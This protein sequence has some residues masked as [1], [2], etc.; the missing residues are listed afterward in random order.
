MQH[1][2]DAASG[3]NAAVEVFKLVDQVSKID[4]TQPTGRIESIGDGSIKFKNVSFWYPH[5]PE[6]VLKSLSFKIS[7]GQSVALV[8]FSGSGKSTVIQLLMR[9]YDPQQGQLLV[10]GNSLADFN[11]AFW[12]RQVG[13]VSQEPVLFDVS[14]EENVKYGC[15]DAT[16]EQLQA[17]AKAAHMDFLLKT[18]SDTDSDSGNSSTSATSN[19][20]GS[21]SG[22]A[23]WNSGKGKWKWTDRVGLRG[24]R[25]S[26]GQKQRCALARALLRNPAILLLDEATSALDSTAEKQVQQAMQEARKG[27]TTITVAH[28]LSTIRN[29]DK[30]FVLSDGQLVESG[31]YDELVGLDGNFAKLAAGSL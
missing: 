2:P 26:G 29:S 19:G 4:A 12:R 10:G 28:R 7:A 6:I 27:K 14:L 25:L 24:E 17:A 21:T 11:V 18:G 22:A 30:I 13:L 16:E 8:G 23:S 9:F 15:W 20:S 3:R 1:I 5:R 31:N